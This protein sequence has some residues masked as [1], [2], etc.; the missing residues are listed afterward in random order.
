MS[1]EIKDLYEYVD[2]FCLKAGIGLSPAVEGALYHVFKRCQQEAKENPM[3]SQPVTLKSFQVESD[4]KPGTWY[5][6]TE[7]V[8]ETW[9]CNCAGFFHRKE[10][11]HAT[12]ATNNDS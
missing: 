3:I 2:E 9:H 11:K 8:D 10:C 4:T 1:D 12:A 7:Q 5:T 6:L